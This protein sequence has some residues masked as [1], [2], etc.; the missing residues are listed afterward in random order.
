MIVKNLAA[1]TEAEQFF[2]RKAKKLDTDDLQVT[3]KLLAFPDPKKKRYGVSYGYTDCPTR[4]GLKYRIMVH[5]DKTA[6]LPFT[7]EHVVCIRGRFHE[8]EIKFKDKEEA[9]VYVLGH[10]FWHYM[11][12]KAVHECNEEEK[13]MLTFLLTGTCIRPRVV[14]CSSLYTIPCHC[15]GTG[16]HFDTAYISSPS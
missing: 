6:K 11:V 14:F 7:E 15:S 16:I 5:V 1:T 12:G 8:C 10:E 13:A 2:R 9:M 4:N 3:M